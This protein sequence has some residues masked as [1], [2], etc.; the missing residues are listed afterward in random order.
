MS[1]IGNRIKNLRIKAGLTQHELAEK[2]GGIS[3]STVGMYEQGRRTPDMEKIILL[4]KIFSVSTDCL[5]GVSDESTE[6][7]DLFDELR[8]KVSN[9]NRLTVNGLAMSEESREKLLKAIEFISNVML[10]QSE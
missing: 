3:A 1:S 9:N 6:A 2:L 5:L 7:M 8:D 4:G 10:S